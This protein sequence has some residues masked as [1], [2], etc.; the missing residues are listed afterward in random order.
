[1]DMIK[2]H[3]IIRPDFSP[4]A[5]GA[6]LIAAAVNLIVI[7]TVLIAVRELLAS[8]LI[9]C[10]CV[11]CACIAGL[12]PKQWRIVLASGGSLACF[13]FVAYFLLG[14]AD[15]ARALIRW[16]WG[17]AFGFD[18]IPLIALVW[19]RIVG[20]LLVSLATINWFGVAGFLWM[21]DARRIPR[22]PAIPLEVLALNFS[23]LAVNYS[24]VNEAYR[25]SGHIAGNTLSLA[26]YRRIFGV[27][28]LASLARVRE[29]SIGVISRSLHRQRT[30]SIYAT[31]SNWPLSIFLL[32]SASIAVFVRY[33]L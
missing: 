18:L 20:M 6:H 16:P 17:S 21:L 26:D 32:T 7:S 19:F 22:A 31:Q 25:A 10:L 9:F 1:M 14:S 2:R 30:A 3:L 29:T 33:Y 24:S 5:N 28:V 11:A 8:L 12:S 23:R 13:L 15:P 4:H 27:F